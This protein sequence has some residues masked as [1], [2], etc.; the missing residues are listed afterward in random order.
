MTFFAIA[1]KSR[2]DIARL[3]LQSHFKLF[4][5][6]SLLLIFATTMF[7]N[8][9]LASSAKGQ[10][11]EKVLVNIELKNES[12]ADAIHKIESQTPFTFLYRSED[13]ANVR[14]LNIKNSK[15]TLSALLNKLLAG[16]TLTFKQSDLRIIIDK[17]PQ[18]VNL[19]KYDENIYTKPIADTAFLLKGRVIEAKT[20]LPLP[21]VTVITKISRGVTDGKG[22]FEIPV[23][24][25][26]RL[27]VLFVGYAP[28]DMVIQN[29]MTTIWDIKMQKA[30]ENAVALS[31]V[32]IESNNVKENPTKFV[33]LENRSYMNLSQVLQGTIP[34]LSLQMVNTSTKTVTSVDAYLNRYYGQVFGAFKRF[35]VDDFLNYFG[36]TQ[37]QNIIDILLRGTNVPSSIS[38]LYHINTTVTVSNALVPEIRGANNF[39]TS[40][41]N[42]LVVID[43]FPQDGFPA[44]Y[45]MTNVESIEVIKDQVGSQ[46]SRRRYSYQVKIG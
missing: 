11:M 13:V 19:E 26:D 10:Q 40:T 5:R 22:I 27:R 44:N 14:S 31:E 36:K 30:S 41:S 18:Q 45:P 37:G 46:G 17:L 15:L 16:T 39:G 38:T 23:V 35:T 6:V 8:L 25:G 29:S 2:Q 43:G 33:D 12:L 9:L 7:S 4:M 21:G 42:M 24:T 20:G 32:N 34:G 3:V 1:A 28:V